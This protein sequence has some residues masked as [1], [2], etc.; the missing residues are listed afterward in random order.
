MSRAIVK[1]AMRPSSPTDEQFALAN[2]K[3]VSVTKGY[4]STVVENA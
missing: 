2:A 4:T 3:G 1:A